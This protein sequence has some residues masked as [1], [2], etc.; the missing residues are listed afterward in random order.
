MRIDGSG[1]PGKIV[2]TRGNAKG[3]KSDSTF[4]VSK[5]SH[6]ESSAETS[7]AKSIGGIDALLTLQSVEPTSERGARLKHGHDMLDLLDDIKIALLS[8]EVPGG[9]LQKLVDAVS[10]RPD[11]YEDERI[12]TV[13]DEIELRARVELAKLG[14]EAK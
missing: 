2:R 1:R 6:S 12:E 10:R 5:E 4:S 8:G 13:L 9:K 14:R 11:R 7:S 3:E